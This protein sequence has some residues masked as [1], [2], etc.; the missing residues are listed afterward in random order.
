MC[1][2]L[3]SLTL[4]FEWKDDMTW[5][6]WQS[7][8]TENCNNSKQICKVGNLEHMMT[9]NPYMA[10]TALPLQW[11]NETQSSYYT[12]LKYLQTTVI[13]QCT[14]MMFN[15]LV[16]SKQNLNNVY[17][18]CVCYNTFSD[19]LRWKQLLLIYYPHWLYRH[20]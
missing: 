3:C 1:G 10:A 15:F 13:F 18:D 7:T 20:D 19:I 6:T 14:G 5:W 4:Y 17:Y 12:L 16:E 2:I 11:F 8:Q 9:T